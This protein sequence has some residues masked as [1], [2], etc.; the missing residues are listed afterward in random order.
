MEPRQAWRS[1]LLVARVEYAEYALLYPIAI[2]GA[3][4]SLEYISGFFASMWASSSKIG[5]SEVGGCWCFI[6]ERL[7]CWFGGYKNGIGEC[8]D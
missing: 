3:K 1:R 2:L 7:T 4:F 6:F 5:V 8:W